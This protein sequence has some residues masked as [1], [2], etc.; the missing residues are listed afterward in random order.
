METRHFFSADSLVEAGCT[1][2]LAM[3]VVVVGCCPWENDSPNW[4]K[5]CKSLIIYSNTFSS[6]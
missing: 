3:H 4:V 6:T 5:A 2:V 1:S